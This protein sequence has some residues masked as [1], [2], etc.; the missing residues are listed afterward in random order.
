M[1]R[2]SK[3]TGIILAGGKST[4][5]GSDKGLL[6]YRGKPM[7]S[8]P[9]ELLKSLGMPIIIISSNNNYEQFG[10]P[11][12]EDRYLNKG[13]VGGIYSGLTSSTNEFNLILPCDTPNLTLEI[14]EHLID[15][16]SGQQVTV[17]NYRG[18][19]HPLVGIYS[20]SILPRLKT[21]ISEN[22]LKMSILCKE[23]DALEV[24]LDSSV[25]NDVDYFAN[26]NNL[27]DLNR[28]QDEHTS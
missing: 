25:S 26:I 19:L 28:S 14:I 2:N 12:F 4:R 27:E 20:K 23:F 21:N 17:P 5:M 18:Q 15:A 8:Y 1:N 10:Y 9:I 13:P 3:M 6:S 22:R 24:V 11:V 16:S 7:I